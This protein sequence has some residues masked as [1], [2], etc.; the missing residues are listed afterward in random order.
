M[1]VIGLFLRL[2]QDDCASSSDRRIHV[3]KGRDRK[4]RNEQGVT[5]KG[6][7]LLGPLQSPSQARKGQN[8]LV[9]VSGTL[10]KYSLMTKKSVLVCSLTPLLA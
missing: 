6:G 5:N 3:E 1:I 10:L 9:T 2:L 8:T 7:G 4:R